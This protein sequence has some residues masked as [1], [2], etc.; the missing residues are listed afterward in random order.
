MTLSTSHLKLSIGALLRDTALKVALLAQ[1]AEP[2]S[3]EHLSAECLKLIA[4]F[5]HALEHRKVA[6]DVRHEAVYAQCGLIDEMVMSH[7]PENV[8]LKWRASPLHFAL[9]QHRDAGERIY[10]R[11]AARMAQIS[12]NL[13]MLECYSAILHLGFS[14]RYKQADEKERTALMT[15]LD[16]QID[17]L[18]STHSHA[19]PASNDAGDKKKFF[20]IGG[21]LLPTLSPWV[22]AGITAFVTLLFYFLVGETLEEILTHW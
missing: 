22:L 19:Q 13:A 2:A 4:I 5:D 3:M 6:D 15:Q 21:L 20:E 11:L 16:A 10:E 1:H 7:L 17:T 12:P 8:K 18:R 9:F 14:G